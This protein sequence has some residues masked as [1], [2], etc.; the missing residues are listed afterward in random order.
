MD[1]QPQHEPAREAAG[2][3]GQPIP[4]TDARLLQRI[5][6]G[7]SAALGL[8][9]DAYSSVL[10][11]LALRILNDHKEAEDVLQEVFLQV[12]DKAVTYDPSL[13]RPLAWVITLTRNKAI[14]RLRSAQR[15]LKLF[16]EAGGEIEAESAASTPT[17]VDKAVTSERANL[18]CGALKRLPP[19]QK[20][21]IELAFFTG[22]TQSEI[23]AALNEPLGTIKARIRRGMLKLREELEPWLR[24][25]VRE[26]PPVAEGMTE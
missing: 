15:R 9:Y 17:A 11:G 10:F 19:E 7:D 18:V 6:I 3:S 1:Y 21:A 23:A 14:D 26:V 13:G 2:E 16:D 24:A 20:H 25:E 8:F 4:D 22:L 12:W 5:A